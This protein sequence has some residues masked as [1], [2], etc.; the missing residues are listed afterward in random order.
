LTFCKS[1]VSGKSLILTAGNIGIASMLADES[2]IFFFFIIQLLIIKLLSIGISI[3]STAA[4][5]TRKA[6]FAT[7]TNPPHTVNRLR[8]LQQINIFFHYLWFQCKCPI[9]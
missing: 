5:R 1:V 3:T 4:I 9:S 2:A 6:K 8:S 7:A